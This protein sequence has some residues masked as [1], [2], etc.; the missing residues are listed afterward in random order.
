MSELTR[1]SALTGGGVVLAGGVIGFAWTKAAVDTGPRGNDEA[2]AYGA[3]PSGSNGS[4]ALAAVSD[5]PVGGGVIRGNIVLTRPS[6]NEIHAFSAI[7]TH[8]G[9][10]VDKVANGHI[11]CPCH[12]SV[13]DASTGAV[14]NG[15]APSPLGKIAIEVRNGEVYR[16]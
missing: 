6:G 9:C 11:D 13:F 12:G 15:P 14:V 8:Q 1:R 3:A 7:C 16:A 5:V 2:N 4:A 10:K